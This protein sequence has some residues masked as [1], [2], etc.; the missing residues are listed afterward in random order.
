MQNYIL[1]IIFP[2]AKAFQVATTIVT[3]TDFVTTSTLTQASTSLY[4][5]KSSRDIAVA[6]KRKFY[7][8]SEKNSNM[9]FRVKEKKNVKKNVRRKIKI[10]LL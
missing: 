4:F 8:K 10:C 3:V 9:L 7:F 6:F 2:L 1:I 5:I